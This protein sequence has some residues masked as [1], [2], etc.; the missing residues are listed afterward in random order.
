MSLPPASVWIIHIVSCLACG[1]MAWGLGR[2]L[3]RRLRISHAARNY[4]FGIWTLAV[5]PPMVAALLEPWLQTRITAIPALPLP[6][7]LAVGLGE[8]DASSVATA[9]S[10]FSFWPSASVLLAIVYASGAVVVGLRRLACTFSV[11]RIVHAAVPIDT[12]T[13][14]GPSSANEA[15]RMTRAGIRLRLTQHAMSPFAV[16]WPRPTIVVSA[17]AL[18]Q[19]NDRQLRLIIRHEAAHLAHCDPQ[20]A[21][22]MSLV[23]TLL[24]FNPFLRLIT[25]RV[26][27]AAELQCD[28]SATGGDTSAGSELAKAYLHTLRTTRAAH[29]PVPDA[30]LMHRRLD[31]HRLRIQHML[32]GDPGRPSSTRL[33]VVLG[34]VALTMGSLLAITQVAV[35]SPTS[36]TSPAPAGSEASIAF[37]PPSLAPENAIPPVPERDTRFSFPVL[38]PKVTGHFGDEGGIRERP[39]RGVDF[40]ARLGTPVLAPAA[41]LVVAATRQYEGGPNYGTVVVLDHGDGWQTL[42][43]HLDSFDVRVG[44]RI[45]VGDRIASVGR[46]GKVTGAHLHFEMLLNGRRIDPEPLLR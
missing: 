8:A 20:R 25:A 38:A 23:G 36:V 37:A 19:L 32:S 3:H 22:L 40:G 2:T 9:F 11:W 41:G 6:L 28:A 42:F 46:T 4:W 43:A 26:Q 14:P 33:H 34:G 1:A 27:M 29:E 10:P 30:A 45:E 12:G 17:D 35:A 21:A 13:W 39:H 24:W 5:L 7:P 15:N 31:S 18:R 44:Q 16:R